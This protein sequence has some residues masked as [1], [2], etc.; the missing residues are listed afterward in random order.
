MEI[1]GIALKAIKEFILRKF[2]TG[3]NGWIDSLSDKS[4][5]IMSGVLLVGKWYPFHEAFVEPFEKACQLSL[6]EKKELP[7]E[8]GRFIAEYNINEIYKVFLKIGSP[9]FTISRAPAI[10][11]RYFRPVKM[12]II[13]NS[14]HKAILHIAVFPQACE[15]V[16]FIMAG[17]MERALE[18]IGCKKPE[19]KI[20]QS[21]AKGNK[22]T[23]F[24]L[25]WK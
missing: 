14:P 16:E 6:D 4:K 10:F 20:S 23:E 15:T 5:D 24:I 9:A 22:V 1:K 18:M 25:Q 11:D 8:C 17:W 7:W 12:N 3:Y 2:P 21:L 19:V 13:E